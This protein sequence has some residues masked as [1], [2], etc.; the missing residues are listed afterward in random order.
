MVDY[1]SVIDS[2]T[3][4]NFNRF[5]MRAWKPLVLDCWNTLIGVLYL[6]FGLVYLNGFLLSVGLTVFLIG[7][8]GYII[9]RK[10]ILKEDRLQ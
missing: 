4:N 10:Q 1:D 9:T 2:Y 7:V 8:V 3:E 5:I 6:S